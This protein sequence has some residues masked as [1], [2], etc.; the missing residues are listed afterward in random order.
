MALNRYFNTSFWKDNYI[1][2]LDPTEKLLFNYLFTNAKANIAG[3]YEIHHREIAFDTGI[4][5]D[6]VI[7]LIGR[8]EKDSKLLYIDG[9]V[10]LVNALKHQ[11]LN[12][13]IVTGIK[14]Q[15][16]ALPEGIKGKVLD[17]WLKKKYESKLDWLSDEDKNAR[18]EVKI[19]EAKKEEIAAEEKRPDDRKAAYNWSAILP[20]L[21]EKLGGTKNIK[22]TQGRIDKLKRRMKTF[23]LA[24][25]EHA[26]T[27]IG[28]DDFLQGDNDRKTKY[29]TIDFLIR[30]DE[31]V[32]KY[33]EREAPTEKKKTIRSF[34]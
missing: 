12:P 4:D 10:I 13:N 16:E 2:D 26:A 30:S 8:F 3:V 33:L 1:V 29:A 6:M 7:K 14:T 32:A 28:A 18:V 22:I 9:W 20:S 24:E 23:T 31:Q 21:N 15:F 25:I 27:V 17:V 34:F 11:K 5:K 19:S